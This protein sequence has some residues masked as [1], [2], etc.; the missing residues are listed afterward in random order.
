VDAFRPTPSP[1]P[2]PAERPGGRRLFT[3]R[4]LLQAGLV[5]GPAAGLLGWLR[6]GRYPEAAA[7][8]GLASLSPRAGAILAA[9]VDA[10]LPP[11]APRARVPAHVRAI[12]DYLRGADP[13]DLSQLHALLYAI[14]HLTIFFGGRIARFSHLDR[15]GRTAVLESWRR[16]RW[17]ECRLGV[18]SLVALVFLACYR[19]SEAFAAIGYPGPLVPGYEGPEES[20]VRYDA[21]AAPPGREPFFP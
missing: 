18:R 9:V 7:Y 12:D 2:P 10:M 20:R 8:E 11:A 17:G 14:E 13:E 21:L 1:V 6:F 19:D 4:R 16:S 15:E 5:A 3:R